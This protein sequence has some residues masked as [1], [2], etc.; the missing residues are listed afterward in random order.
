MCTDGILGNSEKG[1][2]GEQ[3]ETTNPSEMKKGDLLQTELND[4]N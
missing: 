1:W 3:I 2:R 4:T